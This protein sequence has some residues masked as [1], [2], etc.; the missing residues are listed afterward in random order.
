MFRYRPVSPEQREGSRGRT[1]YV[2]G[3][4]FQRQRNVKSYFVKVAR[5]REDAQL[6]LDTISVDEIG[7]H[8]LQYF[9]QGQGN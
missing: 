8:A 3:W 9:F 4:F 6:D 1:K 2:P 5:C 7:H